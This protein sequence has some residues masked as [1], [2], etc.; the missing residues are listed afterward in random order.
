MQRGALGLCI[1]KGSALLKRVQR[2]CF[3]KGGGGAK[4]Q[5]RVHCKGGMPRLSFAKGGLGGG[6]QMLCVATG[7][8]GA[9]V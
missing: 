5:R 4:L 3:A 7:E 9:A 8:R 2:L 1:A 6:V